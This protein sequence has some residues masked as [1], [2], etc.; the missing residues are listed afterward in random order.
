VLAVGSEPIHPNRNPKSNF[1]IKMP[2]IRQVFFFG[3]VTL[4]QA[5]LACGHRQEGS[6]LET[7]RSYSNSQNESGKANDCERCEKWVKKSLD[8]YIKHQAGVDLSK[9]D[10]HIDVYGTVYRGKYAERIRVND[11]CLCKEESL[12]DLV[13]ISISAIDRGKNK[14]YTWSKKDSY[15]LLQNSKVYIKLM[16]M[17]DQ[18]GG[19]Y[20][21]KFDDEWFYQ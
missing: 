1:N 2:I 10:I 21:I 4:L 3:L 5:V 7:G 14:I 9:Y 20:K 16:P 18:Y 17:Q 11:I 8:F 6:L 12:M 13:L 15:Y 19:D